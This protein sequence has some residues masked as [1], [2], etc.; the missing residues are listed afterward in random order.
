MKET[1]SG[2][3]NEG[4]CREKGLSKGNYRQILDT[5]RVHLQESKLKSSCHI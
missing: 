1:L 2:L 4:S 5:T 3:V